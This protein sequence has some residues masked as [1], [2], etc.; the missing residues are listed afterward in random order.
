MTAPGSWRTRLGA[1]LAVALLVRLP[2]LLAATLSYDDG[3]EALMSQDVLRGRFPLFFYGQPAHGAADRYPAALF[4]LGLGPTTLAVK[5]AALAL[6]LVFVGS[7]A[8]TARR[9]YGP[10][11]GTMAGLLV[12]LPPFYLYGWSFD[13]RGHY[14]LML[15]AGAW[16]L[17]LGWRI[18]TEGPA[19]SPARRFVGLG[20]GAGVAW[21][22]NYLSVTFLAPLALGLAVRAVRDPRGTWRGLALRGLLALAGSAAG[23]AP[24]LAYHLGHGL[25][26]LPPGNPASG[27]SAAEFVAS[28]VRDGLPQILGVHPDV[29]GSVTGVVYGLAAFGAVAALA[30]GAGWWVGARSEPGAGG[31]VGALL[32]LVAITLGLSALTGYGAILRYPRYLLPL[33]LALPIFA[34]IALDGLARRARRL[35]WSLLGLALVGQLTGSLIM[36]P[37]LSPATWDLARRWE[38]D[39][40]E[41]L[42]QIR[43][44][45]LTRLYGG[46]RAW[47]YLTD[48]AVLAAEFPRERMIEVARAVDAAPRVGWA[49]RPPTEPFE[50]TLAAAGIGFRR[51]DGSGFVFY[52]D[53]ELAPDAHA[54]LDPAG[55]TSTASSAPESARLAHDR[56]FPTAWRSGPDDPTPFF[57]VDL[58][59]ARPVAAVTWLPGSARELPRALRV[60]VSEDGQDWR[61]V[62]DV[63]AY[64]GPLY[65]SGTR[66]I[67][68]PRRSRVEVRVPPVR[69]RFVRIEVAA[70]PAGWSIREL[71]IGAPA[72]QCPRAYD[73]PALVA[74]LRQA[75]VRFAYADHW[76]SAAIRQASEGAIGVV[77]SNRS[78]DSYN[79]GSLEP[80]V[81]E[82]VRFGGRAIVVEACPPETAEAAAG[83][84]RQAGVGFRRRAIGGL[85]AF[86]AL[87]RIRYWGE[88]VPHETSGAGPD[89]VRVALGAPRPVARL[90]LDCAERAQ[91]RLAPRDLRLEASSDGKAFVATPFRLVQPAAL[92]MSGSR[93]FADLP[94]TIVL[95]LDAQP[96]AAALRVVRTGGAAP[97]CDVTGVRVQGS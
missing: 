19:A 71:L 24:L 33:Y 1:I 81:V 29:W 75:G 69:A 76:L 87:A 36:P 59:E 93:L 95:E 7:L 78:L 43:G 37:G 35:A 58:G 39:T 46:S 25:S 27:E 91:G 88:A 12:A 48:R 89:T 17:L 53:F 82:P 51:L 63:A 66:P 31:T 42:A 77:P 85:V 84:L 11:V 30:V 23:A 8:D 67:P 55:W 64:A 94:R 54:D 2:P 18:R 62:A 50:Q 5:L 4:V 72:G 56:Q 52:H 60:R 45:D 47:A 34:A 9:V 79:R 57:H 96:A 6:F 65:W 90:S 80:D 15:I 13:A 38:I 97:W 74:A 44:L 28:L 32:G 83:V 26:L 22:T 10:R 92:W 21:W 61:T 49:I 73:V 86:D 40:A 70:G 16:L 14:P 20:L 68:R 3:V 41:Q